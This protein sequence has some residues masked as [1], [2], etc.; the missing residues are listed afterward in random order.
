MATYYASV[1]VDIEL[2]DRNGN[3]FVLMDGQLAPLEGGDYSV[4][5]RRYA[6][7]HGDGAEVWVGTNLYSPLEVSHR[8]Y[9]SD[10][11]TGVCTRFATVIKP[12]G[13]I[14]SGGM[15]DRKKVALK[16]SSILRLVE[17]CSEGGVDRVA[18]YLWVE[19]ESGDVMVDVSGRTIKARKLLHY[20]PLSAGEEY[21]DVSISTAIEY[22]TDCMKKL[23]KCGRLYIG[24]PA[25][26]GIPVPTKVLTPAEATAEYRAGTQFRWFAT[27]WFDEPITAKS[28]QW[29][30]EGITTTLFDAFTK[31]LFNIVKYGEFPSYDIDD[32]L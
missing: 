10:I 19:D 15:W 1:A 8:P 9:L 24:R 32:V 26:V 28:K 16:A 7:A 14:P 3:S 25:Q 27:D 6:Y 30:E 23:K 29:F 31:E 20:L 22:I 18:P 21:N 5:V 4:C 11:Q 12:W 13:A 17:T 2:V